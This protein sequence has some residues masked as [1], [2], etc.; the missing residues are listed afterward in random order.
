[1]GKQSVGKQGIDKLLCIPKER[2]ERRK[3]NIE[4]DTNILNDR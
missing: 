3:K 1:M 2:R 4:R